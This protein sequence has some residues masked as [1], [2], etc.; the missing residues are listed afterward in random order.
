MFEG[1]AFST[2]LVVNGI[3]LSPNDAI[4]LT[5]P[6][7]PDTVS[8]WAWV[9]GSG[10]INLASDANGV[11]FADVPVAL[12]RVINS[13]PET[14]AF[15]DIGVLFG[16]AADTLLVQSDVETT[17]L[18]AALPLFAGGLGVIGLMARRRKKRPAG[19]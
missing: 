6:G 10:I 14:G 15:Q 18:P 3:I 4:G 11:F 7:F 12:F 8:D 13:L 2:G 16:L 17:P 9:D 5:E 19:P 1:H